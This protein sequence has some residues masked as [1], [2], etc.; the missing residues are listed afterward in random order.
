MIII[1]IIIIIISFMKAPVLNLVQLKIS[2]LR[3]GKIA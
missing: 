2:S 3:A 1:I